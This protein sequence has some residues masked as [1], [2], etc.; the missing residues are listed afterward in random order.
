MRVSIS[1]SFFLLMFISLGIWLGEYNTRETTS[2]Q[3]AFLQEKSAFGADDDPWARLEE[4]QRM[5]ADPVTGVIPLNIRRKEI[6]FARKIPKREDIYK[7][8]NVRL[9]IEPWESKGPYNVGGR[10]RALALD[11]RNEDI[12][13]AGG[14]SGGMWRSEDGG[15]NWIKTTQPQSLHSVSALVQ[16]TR[17]GNENRWYYGTGEIKGNSASFGQSPFRGDG[18]FKSVDGGFTWDILPSTSDGLVNFFNSPFNYIWKLVINHTAPIDIDEI[19]AATFGAILRSIDG[20]STW[21]VV[22]GDTVLLQLDDNV[23]L[24]GAL[25]SFFTDIIITVDGVFYATLSEDSQNGSEN[26]SLFRGIYRSIDGKNWTNITPPGIVS[27]YRRIV[28]GASPSN[29]KIVYFL[30]D[31]DPTNLWKFTHLSG[32]GNQTQ[33]QWQDLSANIPAFGGQVGDFDA[34]DSYN[35]AVVVHPE[36]EIVVFIGG[37]NIFRSTDGFTSSNNTTWM[38]GYDPEAENI[39]LYPGHHPDQ[40]AMIFYP[41]DPDMMLSAHDGGISRTFNNLAAKVN[42]TFLN[43]GYITGQFYSVDL[44]HTSINDFV[45]GGLQDNGSQITNSSNF[46]SSWRRILGGDGGYCAVAGNGDYFYF[47]FQDSQIFR[48]TLSEDLNLTSCARVD[49]VGGGETPGHGYLRI[50]PFVL[51]PNNNNVMYLAGGDRIWRNANLSQIPPGSQ[52]PVSLNWS[53]ISRSPL[54]EGQISALA[55]SREPRNIVLYGGSRGELFKIIGA[56]SPNRLSFTITSFSFPKNAYISSVAFDPINADNMIV[57]FSNYNVQSLF[58]SENGGNTFEPISGT[59]EEDPD[60]GQGSGP[61]VRWI[62]IVPLINGGS[63]Y[64]AG[65]SAGLFSTTELDGTLTQWVQEGSETIGNVVVNMVKSRYIDGQVVVSTHGN[66]IYGKKF[67][68]VMPLESD[69][70]FDQ[71]A[72]F[73]NYPNPFDDFTTIEFSVPEKGLVQV[74]IY[75][76]TGKDVKTILEAVQFVGLGSLTWDGTDGNGVPV[77]DGIYLYRLAFGAVG[78]KTFTSRRAGRMILRR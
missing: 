76:T 65:T 63:L 12:I 30:V 74:K 68:N 15:L 22:L 39:G 67:D 52:E 50:N 58:Y 23:D 53:Q 7:T 71:L 20:G 77:K 18:I 49:P 26:P 1:A 43:N 25:V 4:F 28:I 78:S 66:G 10:T 11:V 33:G 73:Q 3:F 45:I 14:V 55:V 21:E 42:W 75:D 34:Q 44:D 24:N 35:M 48:T 8:S 47:S 54:F 72:L 41:S 16:D 56:D 64:L 46:R 38:G 51:D 17:P 19:Y 40:H 59:L 5:V 31:G 69:V 2:D 6:S 37:Q 32:S 60:T 29:P 27:L 36:N 13:L 70:Q 9:S 62:E 61:S 57:A